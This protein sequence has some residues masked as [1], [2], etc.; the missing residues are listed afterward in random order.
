MWPYKNACPLSENFPE[1]DRHFFISGTLVKDSAFII[2]TLRWDM[3]LFDLILQEA[4]WDAR[5]FV[6][7]DMKSGIKGGEWTIPNNPEES[8]VY[9]GSGDFVKSSMPFLMSQCKGWKRG[10]VKAPKNSKDKSLKGFN[11]ALNKGLEPFLV[12]ADDKR[13]R[14][15]LRN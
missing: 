11:S 3:V 14:W 15:G 1:K 13:K 5:T 9:E 10:S 8:W 2:V 4:P 6:W 7:Y 12:R